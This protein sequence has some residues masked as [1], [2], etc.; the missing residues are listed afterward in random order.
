MSRKRDEPVKPATPENTVVA[1]SAFGRVYNSP[2]AVKAAWRQG[3]Q[4]NLSSYT[5]KMLPGL[6]SIRDK[7]KLHENGADWVQLHWGGAGRYAEQFV[8]VRIK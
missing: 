8:E 4:F 3:A 5:L 1:R 2:E 7:A 6:G